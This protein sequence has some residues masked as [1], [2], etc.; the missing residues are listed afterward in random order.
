MIRIGLI[1]GPGSGKS[2]QAAHFFSKLKADGIQTELVTEW[3]REA[4]NK[5]QIPPNTPWVQFWIYSEQKAKE[6]CI[7]LKIDYMVTDSPT[8]LSY[9]YALLFAKRPNDNY[10]LIKMYENFLTDLTRY[11]YLFI[12]KREKPYVEDG[13]RAQTKEQAIEIDNFVLSL[14]DIHNVKY[15]FLTGTVEERTNKMRDVIGL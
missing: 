15:H 2:T 6:D 9:V 14:L 5:G 13:T 4:I 12:C 10:L 8:I 1:S 11:D 7:P 3:V